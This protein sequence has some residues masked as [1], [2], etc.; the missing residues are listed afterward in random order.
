MS[1]THDQD[2][3]GQVVSSHFPINQA[4]V[5]LAKAHPNEY[6]LRLCCL[7]YASW[8]I[9]LSTALF[10]TICIILT[11]F[12]DFPLGSN[13]VTQFNLIIVQKYLKCSSMNGVEGM[14]FI[15]PAI[16]E[17]SKYAVTRCVPMVDLLNSKAVSCYM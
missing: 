15:L 6:P 3:H 16:T 10:R 12:V 8:G 7:Y 5:K 11:N 2:E 17:I 13:G 9:I 4:S 1:N 14:I